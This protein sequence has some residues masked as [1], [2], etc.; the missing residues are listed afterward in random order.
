MGDLEEEIK[1]DANFPDIEAMLKSLAEMQFIAEKP[2]LKDAFMIQ[3]K[4]RKDYPE[5]PK[6]ASLKF[7]QRERAA[8]AK[9]AILSTDIS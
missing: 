3:K 1:L 5:P 4:N 2:S 9:T 7:K 6:S 8:Q